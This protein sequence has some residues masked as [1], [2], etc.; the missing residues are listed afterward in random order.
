MWRRQHQLANIDEEPADAGIIA[1]YAVK[2][3]IWRRQHQLANIDEERIVRVS[4]HKYE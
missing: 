1:S 4:S 3:C 2:E